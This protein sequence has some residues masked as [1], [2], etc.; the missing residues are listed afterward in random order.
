MIRVKPYF[1]AILL[2]LLVIA[3]TGR[4][5]PIVD[6]HDRAPPPGVS[7]HLP[8]AYVATSPLS[9]TLDTLTLLAVPQTIWL[10]VIG[11]LLV[12]GWVFAT[13]RTSRRS[14]PVRFSIT[15]GAII[16]VVAVLEAAVIILPRPMAKLEV[17]NPE[18]VR[19]DFHSH[20]NA[21]GDANKRF[22]PADN[23][24]WH[25]HGGFDVAYISDH[26][27]F[28]GADE[29]MR[30]NPPKAGMGLTSLSAVE[31]RYHKIM[32]T[33]MLGLTS[34]DT[35]LLDSKGHLLAAEPSSGRSA[36][37]IVALPNR[38]LDSVTAQSLDS[39]P[40]FAALELVDAA[41][42]GLGQLDRD[43]GKIR[44][45]AGERHFTLVAASNNH[46]W[47]RTVAAWNLMTIPGWRDMAADSLAKEIEQ[48]LRSRQT[49]AVTIVK[50]LRPRTHGA[51]LPFTLF[52]AAYQILASLTLSERAVWLLWIWLIAPLAQLAARSQGGISPREVTRS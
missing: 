26:I 19:I 35:A 31:G 14:N 2:T 36:V 46:G 48:P 27:S 24:E 49:D 23:R 9:R 47:G 8:A 12:I 30:L 5:S 44:Q 40:H 15:I 37:T 20:T 22:T 38:N 25:Q 41:P 17:A 50:R 42:R 10:F 13:P 1:W 18:I 33:I 32:S 45:L 52:V 39:L 6:S 51:T 28:R 16:I 7:L 34:A 21:S 43:E 29:A 3:L 4:A 11:A